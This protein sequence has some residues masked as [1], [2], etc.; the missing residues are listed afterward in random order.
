MKITRLYTGDDGQSHFEDIDIA[1]EDAGEKGA[2]TQTIKAAKLIFWQTKG[3]REFTWHNAPR[4]QYVIV[5]D[6]LEIELGDG[7]KR[8]FETGDILLAEDTAGK[9]HITR[10][11]G[12]GPGNSILIALD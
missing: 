1:L 8:L 9:G 10:I 12:E 6:K 3:K 4:R 7:T 2:L 5:L 11:A